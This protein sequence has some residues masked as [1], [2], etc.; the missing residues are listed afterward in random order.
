MSPFVSGPSTPAP[1]ELLFF[2]F[3]PPRQAAEPEQV[4]KAAEATRNRLARLDVDGVIVYDIDDESDRNENPRPFPYLPAIDPAVYLHEH[5]SGITQPAVVY[6]CVGKYPPDQLRQWLSEQSEAAMTVFVG[7]SS[8]DKPVHTSLAEAMRI[9]QQVRPD[10]LLGGVAI[11][12]R[13]AERGDEHLRLLG[14]QHN[15]CSFFVSQVVYDLGPAKDLVS[16]YFYEATDNGIELKPLVFT[17]S[18]CGSVKTL[19]FLNWLGVGVPVWVQNELLREN[20][21]LGA[22]MQHCLSV[23]ADLADFCRHL[24]MPFGFNVESVSNRKAEIDAAVDLV[25]QVGAVL[26]R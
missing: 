2:G 6:R 8:P 21:I 12:E 15:G 7:A 9:R 24:G 22:S 20:D 25:G 13:H 3:T 10:L 23:A 5:L 16:Q 14:K 1:S 26:R 17:L 11:P 19:E 4:A 18:L